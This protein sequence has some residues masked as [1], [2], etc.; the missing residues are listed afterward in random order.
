MMKA[1]VVLIF[2]SLG[3]TD[4]LAQDFTKGEKR[5]AKQFELQRQEYFIRN[6]A[7]GVA[8]SYR[9]YKKLPC[10]IHLQEGE[11]LIE[12][13]T[14]DTYGEGFSEVEFENIKSGTYTCTLV[15]AGRILDKMLVR[16]ID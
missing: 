3:V 11:I 1:G 14:I 5:F 7:S 6:T 16:V 4:I 9:A 13:K 8:I 10:S 12:S 15:A 2:L